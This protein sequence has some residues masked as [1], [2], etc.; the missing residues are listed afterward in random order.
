MRQARIARARDAD[1]V[2]FA[3]AGDNAATTELHRRYEGLVRSLVDTRVR[4]REDAEDV[5]QEAFAAAFSRLASLARPSLFRAW[6]CRIAVNHAWSRVRS[7]RREEA[8]SDDAVQKNGGWGWQYQLP[9]LVTRERL[10]R[11]FEA[12]PDHV[13]APVTMRVVEGAT[14]PEIADAMGTGVKTAV[15][16]V[17]GGLRT[18]ARHVGA[19]G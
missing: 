19:A 6:L 2:R 16:Q 18:L 13:R 3:L 5:A 7:Q 8:R 12:L 9:A 14:Y 4:Q 10:R 11:A 17:R 15:R 1:L